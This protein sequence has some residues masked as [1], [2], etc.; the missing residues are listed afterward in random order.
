[1]QR[2]DPRFHPR[3]PRFAA[4]LVST[5]EPR[6]FAYRAELGED[7]SLELVKTALEPAG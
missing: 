3:R 7:T 4:P 5:T 6:F 2:R 1:M